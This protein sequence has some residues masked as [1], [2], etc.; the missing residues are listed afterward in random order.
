[1]ERVPPA[2]FFVAL[3]D[4]MNPDDGDTGFR[5][6]T[7]GTCFVK[8]AITK[9]GAPGDEWGDSDFDD[10]Y[11]LGSAVCMP[12]GSGTSLTITANIQ[13]DCLCEVPYSVSDTVTATL[14]FGPDVP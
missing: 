3:D 4:G 9:P 14:Y 6:M 11:P 7:D 13:D 5:Q 8:Y 12:V 1:M 2:G 10:A